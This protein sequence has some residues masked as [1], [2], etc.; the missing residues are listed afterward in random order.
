MVKYYA[1]KNGREPG[2]YRS[3]SECKNQVHRFPGAEFK[4]FSSLED[5]QE[6]LGVK[7]ESKPVKIPA[8][9]LPFPAA[10]VDGSYNPAIR[11]YG[12]GGFI[13]VDGKKYT[14]SGNG[15]DPEM[16]SM[17]NVAGEI[18]GCMAAVKKAKEIGL[19]EL[20]IYY[21]YTGI[22]MWATGQ[23][24]CNKTGTAAYRDFMQKVREDS[25]TVKFR[26]VKGHSGVPGNEIADQLAKEAVGI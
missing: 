21:D 12:Y 13:V 25:F 17:R 2:I 11:V 18:E 4:S 1:V 19:S 15:S 10:Y 26:K 22:E 20:T 24:K 9:N 6:Y 14:F 7:I 23:W 3:W 5:A 8:V 16:A